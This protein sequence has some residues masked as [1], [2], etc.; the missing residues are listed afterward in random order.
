VDKQ[1]PSA[2]EIASSFGQTREQLLDER[3]QEAFG[4]FLSGVMDEYKK[5]KLIRMT[6]KTKEP[7]VPGL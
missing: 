2:A 5:A 3:R 4:V 1:E 7:T 6:E